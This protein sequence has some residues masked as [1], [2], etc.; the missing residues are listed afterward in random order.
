MGSNKGFYL[1]FLPMVAFTRGV[2][3]PL[4][5][6]PLIPK[7]IFPNLHFETG[8]MNIRSVELVEP[9]QIGCRTH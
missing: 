3:E 2:K 8:E 4:P 6:T 1:A 5:G 7:Y 9:L